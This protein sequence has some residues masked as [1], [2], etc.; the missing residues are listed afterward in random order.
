MSEDESDIQIGLSDQG[1][2]AVRHISIRRDGYLR[3]LVHPYIP[4][5]LCC[6]KC[7]RFGH[8]QTSCRGKS[9]CAQCGVEGHQG[10][11]CTTTP[12]CVNCKEAH[13]AYSR[14][15]PTWQR[16]KEIQRVKTVNNLPYPEARRMVNLNAP[17]KQKTFAAVLKSTK[18]CGVQT[19]ISVPSNESLTC[20]KNVC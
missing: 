19:D 4:N 9:L 1:V 8:S 13:P 18:T 2:I 17:V 6:F 14:K 7:Q 16:E 10:T 12:C 3:C 20:T 11:E 5:R 15:C